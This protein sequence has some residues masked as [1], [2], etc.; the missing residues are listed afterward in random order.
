VETE[1]WRGQKYILAT[2]LYLMLTLS[3]LDSHFHC[4]K[5]PSNAAADPWPD[6]VLSE[7]VGRMT[8]MGNE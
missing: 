7:P 5:L 2:R 4:S 3:S 1:T 8:R 6:T